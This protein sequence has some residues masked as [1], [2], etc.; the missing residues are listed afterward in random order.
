[1]PRAILEAM[2]MERPVVVTTVGGN[3]EAVRDGV[4]GLLVPPGDP[5]ALASAV[6][7]VL[8]DSTLAQ[9][10]GKRGRQRVVECFSFE[11]NMRALMA[12]HHSWAGKGSA[13]ART[14]S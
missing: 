1:M 2:A 5:E 9:A 3:P 8:E 10:L 7:R 6:C 11:E 4:D 14:S 13:D 12:W